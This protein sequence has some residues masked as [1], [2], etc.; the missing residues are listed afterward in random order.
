M[1]KAH[2]DKVEQKFPIAKEYTLSM[3]INMQIKMDDR[4]QTFGRI[5]TRM[6]HGGML[7]L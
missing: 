3:F 2:M 4:S 7:E 6:E 5:F 1:H